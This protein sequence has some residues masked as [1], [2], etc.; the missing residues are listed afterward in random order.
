MAT[1]QIP[2]KFTHLCIGSGGVRGL[3]IV[4]ALQALSDPPHISLQQFTHFSGVSI[5]SLMGLMLALKYTP[6][7]MQ[8]LAQK[9]ELPRLYQP[10]LSNLFDL[11]STWGLSDGNGLRTLV[12]SLLK[13]KDLPPDAPLTSVPNFGAVVSNVTEHR[14]ELWRDNPDIS[15]ADAVTASCSIPFAFQPTKHKDCLYVDG[16]LYADTAAQILDPSEAQSCFTLFVHSPKPTAPTTNGPATLLAYTD[17]VIHGPRRSRLLDFKQAHPGTF[18]D[19]PV[20]ASVTS[21]DTSLTPER[22][23]E[24]VR[25]GKDAVGAFPPTPR[26]ETSRQIP[27]DTEKSTAP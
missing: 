22:I 13:H 19:I 26:T 20:D 24:I 8:E 10:T 21:L 23:Q 27:S 1:L 15:I 3:A 2:S 25:R 12:Q 16:C 7:D 5:G 18:L 9:L 14:P 4:G 11:R 6:Q 17:A